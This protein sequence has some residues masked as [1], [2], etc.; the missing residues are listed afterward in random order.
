M[1]AASV[2]KKK[3]K[4]GKKNAKLNRKKSSKFK[5]SAARSKSIECDDWDHVEDPERETYDKARRS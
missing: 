3:I 4:K 1:L 2:A 5:I